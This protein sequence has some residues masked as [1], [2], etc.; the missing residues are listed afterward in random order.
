MALSKNTRCCRKMLNG[1]LA[2]LSV[3]TLAPRD[4]TTVVLVLTKHLAATLLMHI[5]RPACMQAST[6]V[7]STEK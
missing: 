2:G 4:L 3:V 5:T 6:L 1:H 7:V